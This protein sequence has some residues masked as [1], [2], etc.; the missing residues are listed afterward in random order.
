MSVALLLITHAPV[1]QAMLQAATGTLGKLSLPTAVLDVLLDE[2]PAQ[3]L[4]QAEALL[5]D[6]DE[7]DGVLVLT[8]MYGSTPSNIAMQ[9]IN[10]KPNSYLISGINL[11]MLIRTFNYATLPVEELAKK[12]FSGGGHGIHLQP[13]MARGEKLNHA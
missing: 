3:T 10:D 7:G 12:A 11:P 13:S 1:G 9:L 4:Q 2:D 6:I 5:N 8:D